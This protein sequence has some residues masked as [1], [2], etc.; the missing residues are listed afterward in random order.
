MLQ[1]AS[2]ILDIPTQALD[3][4]YTYALE[5]GCAAD[6]EPVEV[7]CA[8][9]VPL[10]SRK[11]IGFVIE[12]NDFEEEGACP[13]EAGKLKGVEKVL[14]GPYFDEEGA[15]CAQFLADRYIAPLSSCIRLFA[16]PGGVPH[17]VSGPYGQRVEALSLIHISLDSSV[18]RIMGSQIAY[19]IS[20]LP[21][22][23]IIG[24]VRFA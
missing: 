13:V 23:T 8:V 14:A 18:N 2:V 1:T 5:E 9:L 3:A 16:P 22:G 20:D 21:P 4:P 11:A 10:G 6:G 7:G 15:A 19:L 12:V 17:L 24:K